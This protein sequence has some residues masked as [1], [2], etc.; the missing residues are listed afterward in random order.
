M[1]NNLNLCVDACKNMGYKRSTYGGRNMITLRQ[2]NTLSFIKEYIKKYD[3]SPTVAEIAEGIGLQSRGVVHRYLRAL[4]DAGEIYLA[5]R[6]HRN[7]RLVE[8]NG[9][10]ATLPILGRIAAGRPIEAI[11]DPRTIDLGSVFVGE[12]R[13]ALQIHGDSMID[14]GIHDGD[15]VICERAQTAGRGQVVVVLIDNEQVTLKRWQP[16]RDGT[17]T[18][19]PAN[20]LHKPMIY[21]ADRLVIQ[22]LYIGLVRVN[23]KA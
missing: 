14:D 20:A 10:G 6:R 18:L 2:R 11:L 4:S 12:R 3:H 21:K 7:I 1:F 8:R 9:S 16:N 19:L 13:Y 5:P 17:V 22:G 23:A 15:I